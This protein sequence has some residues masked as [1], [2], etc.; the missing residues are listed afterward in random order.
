M[1]LLDYFFKKKPKC[2]YPEIKKLLPEYYN[3]L[4]H[5]IDKYVENAVKEVIDVGDY[6]WLEHFYRK[7]LK[8]DQDPYFSAR[9]KDIDKV[10]NKYVRGYERKWAK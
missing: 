6:M 7:K 2:K 8:P 3:S 4:E 5:Y 10:I 9:A 1:S